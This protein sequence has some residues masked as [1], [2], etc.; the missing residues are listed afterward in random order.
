MTT[1]AQSQPKVDLIKQNNQ[2]QVPNETDFIEPKLTEEPLLVSPE[3]SNELAADPYDKAIQNDHETLPLSLELKKTLNKKRDPDVTNLHQRPPAKRF[4]KTPSYLSLFQVKVPMKKSQASST[5]STLVCKFC[6][7]SFSTPKKLNNHYTICKQNPDH[8]A[9]PVCDKEIGQ[10][11]I[12]GH[13]NTMHGI[14]K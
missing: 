12:K 11:Y 4:I 14:K 1:D 6:S 10:T 2:T 7:S 8:N 13:L 3:T 5:S 9:C